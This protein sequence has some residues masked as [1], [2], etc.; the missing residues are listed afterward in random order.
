[1]KKKKSLTDPLKEDVL[2][3]SSKLDTGPGVSTGNGES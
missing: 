3:L 1:M 2:G